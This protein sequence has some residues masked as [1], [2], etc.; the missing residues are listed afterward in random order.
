MLGAVIERTQTVGF[1]ILAIVL[2]SFAWV[3]AAAWG[4]HA[5]GWLVTQWGLHDFGVSALVHAIAG[6]FALGFYL[7]FRPK[8]GKFNADGRANHLAG[9][10]MPMSVTSLML[11]IV[12]FWGF[13]MACVIVPSEG[14]S[15]YADAP[16]TIYGTPITIPASAF[17]V[18]MGIA[19]GII[20]AWIYT[21]DPSR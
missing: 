5:D 3:I 7:N 16:A 8:I 11:I 13:L 17:N 19:G 2:G 21:K 18:L 9:R 1:T 6:L 10:N 20:G 14:F 12:G 15:W 4:W